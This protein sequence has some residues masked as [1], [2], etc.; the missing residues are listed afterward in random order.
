MFATDSSR[1]VQ[2]VFDAV[3][4]RSYL[5]GAAR[6]QKALPASG[7]KPTDQSQSSRAANGQAR[8]RSYNDTNNECIPHESW[9]GSETNGRAYKQQ[10]RGSRQDARAGHQQNGRGG[11]QSTDPTQ[12][13]AN[14]PPMPMPPPGMPAFDP[15]NPMAALYAMQEALGLPMPGTHTQSQRGGRNGS[16]PGPQGQRMCRDYETKGYC[17][18]GNACKFS[19]GSGSIYVPPLME[20]YSPFNAQIVGMDNQSSHTSMSPRNESKHF[21]GNDRGRGRGQRGRG[22]AQA[23]NGRAE[24]SAERPNHDKSNTTLVI[25]N[26]PD[27]N[28]SDAEIRNFF[29]EFGTVTTVKIMADRR[30]ALVTYTD[31]DAAQRAY[32]S[33]KVIFDNRFVKVYWY[34]GEGS[35][36]TPRKAKGENGHTKKEENGDETMTGT[37]ETTEPKIDLEAFRQKQ[38]EMQKAHEEKMK[39]KLEMEN[40]QAEL[41]KRQ[42]ELM[43]SQAEEKRRLMAKLAAKSGS[44]SASEAGNTPRSQSEVLKAQ[45]AALEAEA[46]SLGIDPNAVQEDSWNGMNWRG[47]GRGRGEPRGGYRGRASPFTPRGRGASRGGFR[48]RG[49]ASAIQYSGKYNLDNR[50]RTIALGGHDFTDPNKDESLREYLLVSPTPIFHTSTTLTEQGVD[51]N[52]KLKSTPQTTTLSFIDRATAEKFYYGLPNG[53]LP[54]IGKVEMSWMKTPLPQIDLSKHQQN[55]GVN[56]GDDVDMENEQKNGDYAEQH[57]NHQHQEGRQQDLDY[58]VEEEV[59]DW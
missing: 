1:F 17:E 4:S 54:G 30:L 40:A 53:E 46:M 12:S 33:P 14:L 29:S 39:K 47:R 19:H 56:N 49:A 37:E 11:R 8:K 21:R 41:K 52:V 34:K 51:E 31:W 38:E 10:R 32:K 7:S 42:E 25:E 16:R 27:E 28:L 26:I 23:S 22:N 57:N 20:E 43:K 18:R 13:Y 55:G 36:P 59:R 6:V 9:P 5:P 50:P 45:L 15:N 48:G 2:D 24:F 35:L 3:K 58:D 44:P